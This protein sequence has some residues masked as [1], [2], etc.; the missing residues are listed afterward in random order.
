MIFKLIFLLIS[1]ALAGSHFSSS[2]SAI[3]DAFNE[4][5]E[6]GDIN[7]RIDTNLKY[8][9]SALAK[10]YS[11]DDFLLAVQKRELIL[12]NGKV[13]PAKIKPSNWLQRMMM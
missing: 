3:L 10:P 8:I 2:S 11:N 13:D 12:K 5:I 7:S 1:L 4:K 9:E 6:S